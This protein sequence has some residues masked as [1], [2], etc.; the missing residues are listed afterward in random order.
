MNNAVLA[1][2]SERGEFTPSTIAISSIVG[3]II[4]LGAMS[5]APQVIPQFQDRA[6]ADKV[7]SVARAQHGALSSTSRYQST[8]DLKKYRWIANMP[9]NIVTRS[10]QGG[11]CFTVMGKSDAGNLWVMEQDDKEPQE[12][13]GRWASDCLTSTQFEDLAF[14]V[15]AQIQATGSL[16]KTRVSANG[17]TISWSAVPGATAYEVTVASENGRFVETKNSTS[18]TVAGADLPGTRISVTPINAN[19]TG[20]TASITVVP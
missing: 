1:L 13:P 9:E 17:R 12:A 11:A 8:A 7:S 14:S 5:I 3:G 6:T 2:R 10:G 20:Q 4:L 19:Q 15:G 16:G 18:V